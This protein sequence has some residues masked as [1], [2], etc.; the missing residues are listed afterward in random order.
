MND[1]FGEHAA[2]MAQQ[3]QQQ[4]DALARQQQGLGIGMAPFGA[5]LGGLLGW[6]GGMP[7]FNAGDQGLAGMQEQQDRRIL[8]SAMFKGEGFLQDV[9]VLPAPVVGPLRVEQPFVYGLAFLLLLWASMTF[10]GLIG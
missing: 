1:L 3:Q 9:A 6:P 7:W 5:A 2:M 4:F 10:G 8:P